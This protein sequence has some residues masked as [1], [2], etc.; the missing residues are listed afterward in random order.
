METSE[1]LYEL[2]LTSGE[3]AIVASAV[4]G[5]SEHFLE[6]TKQASETEA[7]KE[8]EEDLDE[9]ILELESFKSRVANVFGQMMKDE[10][11]DKIQ[12]GQITIG[13][14]SDDECGHEECK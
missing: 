2:S 9:M 13:F 7:G 3:V 10:I 8:H 14:A 1:K 4:K 6:F 5:F 12:S 11:I